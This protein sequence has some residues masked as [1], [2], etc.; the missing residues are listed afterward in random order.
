[1]ANTLTTKRYP[2]LSIAMSVI[3]GVSTD[4]ATDGTLR[5]RSF[6]T[7]PRKRWNVE[8]TFESMAEADAMLQFY[9]ANNA[10][11]FNIQL[12]CDGPLMSALFITP[13]RQSFQ[14]RGVSTLSFTIEQYP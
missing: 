8:Y 2:L 13:P 10:V 1:M 4:R 7:A 5:G 3:D 14:G 12:S 9:A 6:F 11:P